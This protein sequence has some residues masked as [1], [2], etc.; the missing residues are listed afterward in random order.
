MRAPLVLLALLTASV[1]QSA[2]LPPDAL[3]T[4]TDAA[5]ALSLEDSGAFLDQFDRNMPGYAALR[6]NVEGLIGGSQPI[7]TIESITNEGDTQKQSVELDWLLGLNE[8][9]HSGIR[10]ETRRGIIKCRLELRGR[11]WIIV[12]L[13]PIDFF[14]P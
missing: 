14:R 10:K 2:D 5:S 3:R 4:I 7:S 6:A 12:A 8:K 11:R 1:L 13:E 9:D